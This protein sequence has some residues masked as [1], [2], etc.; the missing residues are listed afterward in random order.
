MAPQMA[1]LLA[2]LLTIITFLTYTE[3]FKTIIFQVISENII[4]STN[5]LEEE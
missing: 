3:H 4:C 1:I 5:V 2:I